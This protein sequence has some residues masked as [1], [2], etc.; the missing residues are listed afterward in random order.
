MAEKKSNTLTVREDFQRSFIHKGAKPHGNP[1]SNRSTRPVTTGRTSHH[2][3][4]I[5]TNSGTNDKE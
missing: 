2:A 4:Q 3:K 5:E 1:P